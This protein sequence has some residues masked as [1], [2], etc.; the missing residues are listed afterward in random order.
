MTI[1]KNKLV[2]AAKENGKAGC[3]CSEAIAK[4]FAR[5][6]G[7]DEGQAMAAVSGL[8]GGMGLMGEVCGVVAACMVILGLKYGPRSMDDLARRRMAMGKAMEFAQSFEEECG[9]L[10]CRD[11]S[12]GA[13]LRTEEDARALRE[14]GR[15][16][17]LIGSGAQ[18][19]VEM[20]E[21][22]FPDQKE[23]SV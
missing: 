9:S 18:I 22:P 20:L 17:R 1:D 2:E 10:L 14:S 3:S 8:A 12:Q 19:L 15:P 13:Q 23:G 21:K 5:Y 16:E 7:I 4:A 6:V 11:L